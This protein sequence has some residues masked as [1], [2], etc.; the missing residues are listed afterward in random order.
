MVGRGRERAG[1][2]R[3]GTER[4]RKFSLEEKKELKRK[5][6]SWKME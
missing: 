2:G 1:R 4:Q 3:K 6:K 5:I